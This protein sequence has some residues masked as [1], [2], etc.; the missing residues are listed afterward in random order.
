[1]GQIVYDLLALLC[2]G[3]L[4]FFRNKISPNTS[5][6]EKIMFVVLVLSRVSR[7]SIY[8]MN[9]NFTS[10]VPLHLCTISS[11]LAMIA[12]VYKPDWGK[13]F[14]F[15]YS[16]LGM[17][18]LIEAGPRGGF[19]FDNPLIYG[20]VIDHIT[21]M[22]VPFYMVLFKGY[23]PDLRNVIKPAIGVV[24]LLLLSN[25]VNSLWDGADFFEITSKPVYSDIFNN[26]SNVLFMIAFL[27]VFLLFSV[28]NVAIMKQVKKLN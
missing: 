10:M 27:G 19:A 3:L 11:Y 16:F 28:I 5:K 1:M 14:L 6:I 21:I 22:L 2:I 17:A 18:T 12:C 20:F 4:I 7:L 23:D 15:F 8:L 25:I 24:L 13:H 26:N 9:S